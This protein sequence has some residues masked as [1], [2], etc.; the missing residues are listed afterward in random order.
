MTDDNPEGNYWHAMDK[1]AEINYYFSNP[2]MNAAGF[3]ISTPPMKDQLESLKAKIFQGAKHVE[4]GFTSS[5]MQKG[6]ISGGQVSPELVGRREREAMQELSR[7]NELSLSVHSSTQVS[8]MTG[9]GNKGYDED[10]RENSIKELKRTI[11]FAADVSE[12]GG[13]VVVHSME[14]PRAITEP[15]KEDK[16]FQQFSGVTPGDKTVHYLV[17]EV[18]GEVTGIR[19]DQKNFI[20]EREAIGKEAITGLDIERAKMDEQKRIFVPEERKWNWYLDKHE[21]EE[22]PEDEAAKHFYKD[23]LHSEY[24]HLKGQADQWE[25]G[26]YEDKKREE[27]LLKAIEL[28]K[29]LKE[30]SD[31]E[32]FAE[33]IEQERERYQLLPGEKYDNPLQYLQEK[34]W[35]TQ[36]RISYHEETAVSSRER[37]EEIKDK[38][39]RIKSMKEFSIQKTADGYAQLGIY[40]YDKEKDHSKPLFVAPENIYPEYFGGHPAELKEVIQKSRNRMVEL[41]TSP[42]VSPPN[43]PN[44]KMKN[45][46][47]NPNIS[48]SEAEKMAADRIKATFDV[49]HANTW[50]KYFD[51]SDEEFKKWILKQAKDLEKEGILG[52]VHIS[53]NFGYVDDHQMPGEG[54]APIEDFVKQLQ[55]GDYKGKMI[56]EPGHYDYKSLQAAMRVMNSPVYKIQGDVVGWAEIENAHFGN[57]YT[58]NYLVG[59]MTPNPKEWVMWSELPME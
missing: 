34:L 36:R 45:Q 57:S 56:V 8:G 27:K 53:D 1:Q 35:E 51:G 52:H 40:A 14:Y 44:M 24:L 19:E 25:Q 54:N 18:T 39:D 31:P 12:D 49:A 30:D 42:E 15:E 32:R 11:D 5:P 10:V 22:H 3:G 7:I 17:D 4:L 26:F 16:R 48:K 59:E 23:K 28:A 38:M 47:Y 20:A 37:M 6:S 13:A 9:L 55:K 50:R 2:M 46:F 58:P 29:K 43:R 21:K 33:A 41:L